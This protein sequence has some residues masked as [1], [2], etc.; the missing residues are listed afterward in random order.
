MI[1]A[2]AEALGLIQLCT[3][4]SLTR[5]YKVP[6]WKS[7]AL[8]TM[9]HGITSSDEGS[10]ASFQRLSVMKDAA[11]ARDA[12]LASSAVECRLLDTEDGQLEVAR[13]LDASKG[14]KHGGA[15]KRRLHE[16]FFWF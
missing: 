1:P 8:A 16:S 3:A 6:I 15:N 10:D 11:D 7:S 9:H 2:I 12:I 4:I 14:A 5:A 13:W